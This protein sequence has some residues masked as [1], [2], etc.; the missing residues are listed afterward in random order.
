MG[1]TRRGVGAAVLAALAVTACSGGG[2][3]KGSAA[4]PTT[5]TVK[6]A[7]GTVSPPGPTTTI[8]G[9]SPGAPTSAPTVGGTSAPVPTTTIPLNPGAAGNPATGSPPASE[10]ANGAAPTTT[11]PSTPD[12]TPAP[13]SPTSTAA[14]PAGGDGEPT[15]F[16]AAVDKTLPL[17]FVTL[18]FAADESAD[19]SAYEVAV[20]PALAAPVRSAASSAPAAVAPAFQK[21]AD[22]TA[23]AVA[24]LKTAGATD[25]QISAFATSYAAQ[26][27]SATSAGGDQS[28]PDPLQ[29]AAKA[30]IDSNRVKAAA[31]AFAA[32]NGSYDDFNTS[33][34]QALSLSPD[35]QD[36]LGQR[37][38]CAAELQDFAN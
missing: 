8:P 34:G 7:A 16:C 11:P 22:R 4:A 13:P 24:A 1:A 17:Y 31:S 35:A 20:A 18:I 10:P 19:S 37:Y 25:G 26:V 28:P 23:Q 38:P 21:W 36:D 2:G 14:A 5:T 29:A 6:S 12:T 15:T 33:F 27:E 3:S 30:G 9:R 32:A